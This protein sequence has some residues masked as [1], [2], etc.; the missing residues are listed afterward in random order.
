MTVP[1]H[2]QDGQTGRQDGSLGQGPERPVRRAQF[3]QTVH[4][5]PPE[6][7]ELFG[8]GETVDVHQLGS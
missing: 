8:P 7:A 1:H 3:G 6:G 4:R 5:H 2:R